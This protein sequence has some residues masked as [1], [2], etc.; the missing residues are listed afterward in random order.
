MGQAF[1]HD[2]AEIASICS[3]IPGASAGMTQLAQ[4]WNNWL[5]NSCST[6]SL[7]S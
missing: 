5:G 2:A 7:Y 3:V 4:G 6:Q 1:G